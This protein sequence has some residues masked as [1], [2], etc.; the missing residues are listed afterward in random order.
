MLFYETFNESTHSFVWKKPAIKYRT[1]ATLVL[2]LAHFDIAVS[3]FSML[4]ND[5]ELLFKVAKSKA[6][7]LQQLKYQMNITTNYHKEHKTNR[8]ESQEVKDIERH[9][10]VPQQQLHNLQGSS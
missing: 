8:F 10:R 6:F 7:H 9:T 4:K 5:T 1:L 2:A 3:C